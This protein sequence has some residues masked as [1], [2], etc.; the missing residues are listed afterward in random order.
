MTLG[1]VDACPTHGQDRRAQQRYLD[2]IVARPSQGANRTSGVKPITL[3]EMSFAK[4]GSPEGTWLLR[5]KKDVDAAAGHLDRAWTDLFV[6]C[7]SFGSC[8]GNVF[9]GVGESRHPPAASFL[10]CKLLEVVVNVCICDV[11]MMMCIYICKFGQ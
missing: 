4:I 3:R 11:C 1:G 6:L 7:F 10:A 9:F 8:G 5:I 2:V